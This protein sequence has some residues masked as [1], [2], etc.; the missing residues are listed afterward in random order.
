VD[1][2]VTVNDQTNFTVVLP[3]AQPGVVE[4]EGIVRFVDMDATPQDSLFMLP[5]DSLN[6]SKLAGFDISTNI[7]IDRE[8]I[9]NLIIDAGNGDFISMK[10]EGLL[11]AGIDPSGKITLVGS[12][13]LDEGSYEISFNFLRRR[14]DIQKGSRILWTGEPTNAD[15]NVSAVYVA[16]TSPLDLIQNQLAGSQENDLRLAQSRQRLPFEVWLT[17]RGE[18]LKP[19]ITFDIR[20]PEDKN[21][22]VDKS[23]VEFVQNRLLQIRQEPGEINK[24]VF[25]LLLLNRFV[26]DNPFASSS[27]GLDPME[28]ARQS[29]S[30]LLTEQLNNLVGGVIA[31]VDINFD[32]TT[33]TDYT[34]GEKQS[35]T[36]FTVGLTK[37]LLGDRL[38]VSVGSNFELEGPAPTQGKGGSHIAGNVAI[39]Y[40]LSR[41]GRY[42]IR[43]YRKNEY[44]GIIE[45]YIIESGVGFIINV[46]YD[47]FKELLQRSKRTKKGKVPLTTP[48]ADKLKIADPVNTE[49]IRK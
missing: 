32:L 12:Y 39:D 17:L 34:T 8:A 15:I 19:A 21:Y 6:V 35:R 44:E 3:Q 23:I 1:G 49:K 28:F 14:F 38:T 46:D 13:E 4:R 33:A 25:A 47:H 11:S 16:N 10:G 24:Q 30:K 9:F 5:Y 43:V 40:K 29:V 26:S 42:V 37:Q 2:S 7:T 20:L 22:V 27:G 45:G 18:L 41:D 36:D 48:S 31:G